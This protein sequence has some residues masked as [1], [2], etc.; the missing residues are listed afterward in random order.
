LLGLEKAMSLG[1]VIKQRRVD[2]DMTQDEVA[3]KVNISKPYLSNIETGRA[4][5]PP[6]ERIIRAL[7]RTL[8]FGKG[9]LAHLAELM[10]TPPKVRQEFE[11]LEGEV[12]K[13]RALVKKLMS[14]T[15]RRPIGDSELDAMGRRAVGGSPTV[16]AGPAIPIINK[17]VAGYPAYFTDMDYP[18]GVAEDYIRCPDVHDPQAF[19]ARVVGDSM[20]PR[21]CE[22]DI[23]IFTPNRPAEPGNDCFVRFAED[24][25]TTFKRFYQDAENTIRLQPLNSKYPAET[26]PRERVT[27]LWPSALCIQ[28]PR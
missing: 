20:S 11:L 15:G 25:G 28:K 8:G 4:A 21:Y 9:E 5:N 19:A 1:D 3:S 27:G 16:S 24:G 13:L 22:G 17:V 10:L 18:P 14:A 23:V 26:Y 6:A 7:E 12:T 2:R